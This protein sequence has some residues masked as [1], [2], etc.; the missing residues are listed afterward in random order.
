[1][2]VFS[3]LLIAAVLV[4]ALPVIAGENLLLNPGFEEGEWGVFW[5]K[6]TIP[7]WVYFGTAGE[8]QSVYKRSGDKALKIWDIGV[9]VYQ[10]F[11]VS[12]KGEY[13]ISGYLYTPSDD[14]LDNMDGV[15]EVEWYR[16][17]SK[18]ASEEIGWFYGLN[19]SSGDPDSVDT[20]KLLSKTVTA[21]FDADTGRVY[22]H[23]QN[24]KKGSRG[25]LVWDDLQV[26]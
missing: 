12:D 15:L 16:N 17:G 26:K 20:W 8:V 4:V 3:I 18:L 10:D 22:L 13:E 7:N 5:E 14:R 24:K 25:V 21:P 19:S 23:L 9:G 6:V 2:K 1:M 11:T